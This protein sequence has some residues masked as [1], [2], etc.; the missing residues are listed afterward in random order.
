[1]IR[2]LSPN[3]S[4]HFAQCLHFLQQRNHR[5][6]SSLG[7]ADPGWT[8]CPVWG[9]LSADLAGQRAHHPPDLAGRPPPPAHVLLPLPPLRSGHLLHHQRGPPD[10]GALPPGEEDHL[11]H[12]TGTQHFSL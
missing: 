8:L 6:S 10:A 2:V 12:P 3:Q 7:Q 1:A 11:L 5:S 9:R 4:L